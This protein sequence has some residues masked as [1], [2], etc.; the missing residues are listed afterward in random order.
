MNRIRVRRL[1]KFVNADRGENKTDPE[2]ILCYSGGY[3]SVA[4]MK[5]CELISVV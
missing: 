1:R 3:K 5:S 2:V 4:L